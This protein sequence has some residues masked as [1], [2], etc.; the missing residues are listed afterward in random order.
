MTAFNYHAVTPAGKRIRGREDSSSAKALASSLST[1]G[2]IVLEV[3]EGK[4]QAEAPKS[5][6]RIRRS[7]GVLAKRLI[8]IYKADPQLLQRSIDPK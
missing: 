4:S 3:A 1:R 8:Q 2:L 5:E 6:F 7:Q